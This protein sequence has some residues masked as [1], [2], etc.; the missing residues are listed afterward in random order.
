MDHFTL[1]LA[2]GA[3]AGALD[4]IPMI[5]QNLS[6][7]SCFSAFF[8]YFFAAVIVFYS[9]LPYLPWWA[10]GMAVTLMLMIPV[11][12]TFS[13]KDRKAIPVVVF[14]GLLFGF[15][16]GVAERYLELAAGYP[17]VS[18]YVH[19]YNPDLQGPLALC[20]AIWGSDFYYAFYEEPE[21]VHDALD[22]LADTFIAF[23]N[24][25]H[26]LCPTIDAEHC[27]EWGCLHR[28]RC[29]IRNDA[30]MNISGEMYQTFA[31]PRDARII[32]TFGGG[33]HFCGRGDHYIEHVGAID[34]ISCVNLSEPYMNDMEKIYRNTIDRGLIIFGLLQSEV[35]RALGEG[36]NLRGRVGAG[37]SAAAWR[38]EKD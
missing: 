31:M 9:D 12:F 37:A 22:Y 2:V 5:F 15:L 26:R 20:E 8:I 32:D 16:I 28:G 4:V 30:A 18:R 19:Y 24:R 23:L 33:I 7:R 27:V 21:L 34:G 29:I 35:D 13:G 1:S 36:R 6:A 10:D 25:W 17:K 14:N 3:V 11:L 38:Q